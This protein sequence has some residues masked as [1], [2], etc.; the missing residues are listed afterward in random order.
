ML[1]RILFFLVVLNLSP[2][3]GTNIIFMMAD[4][5]GYGDPRCYNPESRI[6]TPHMDRLAA[7]GMRFTDA[8]TPSAVCTPTRYGV[9]TG[10]YAWRTHLKKGVLWGNSPALIPADRLTVAGMLKRFGYHTGVVGKWHLGLGDGLTKETD[11]SRPIQRGAKSV[12]FEYSYIIPASLDMDP[13][14]W[15]EN[16]LAVEAP[17][18]QDPGSKRVWDGGGGFWRA[19]LRAP[20]FTFDQVLPVIANKAADYIAERAKNRDQPFFLYVPLASPHTPWVPSADFRGKT[21]IGAYG[22]FVYETD[23]ALGK[24]LAALDE[25]ALTEDTLVIFT[26]D[27]GSHWPARMIG[28]SQHRANANWRGQKA[29]IHE[30]GHRVPF[31]VRWPAQVKAGTVSDQLICLTDLMATAAAIAGHSLL[32]SEGEDSFDLLPVLTGQTKKAVR[33][34]I[35]HHSL[36]GLFAIRI[37]KWKL[38]QGQGSGGFTKVPVGEE[39]P[40][41]QLYDLERDPSEATNL[42]TEKPKTVAKLQD[43]L[44]RFKDQG[45][46]RLPG[47]TA[48]LLDKLKLNQF[49][50][51]HQELFRTILRGHPRVALDAMKRLPGGLSED[52]ETH[53]MRAVAYSVLGEADQSVAS[54][55][56]AAANGV[57]VERIIGGT[58]TGLEAVQD[59][60]VI[61]KIREAMNDRVIHGPMLGRQTGN[62]V[63]VWVRTLGPSQ[64]T[65]EVSK[66][67]DFQATVLQGTAHSDKASDFTAEVLVDGLQPDT[68]YFYRLGINDGQPGEVHSF[69][70]LSLPHSPT[71][72]R[73]AFGGGAG[74]VPENERAWDTIRETNPQLLLLLGDNVYSDDPESPAMQHYCY[75]RRQAR[76][77][78]ARLVSQTPTY[79]IWDDHD[80]GLNDCVEGP[81]MDVPAWKRPVYGVY[82][83][84]WV[85]PGYGAGDAHPGCY[86]DFYQGDVH[87]IM[88]DGRYYR[89]LDETKGERSMLGPVQRRWLLDKLKDSQGVFKV[90]VS[91]VPWVFRAK[92]DSKDTWNGFKAERGIIFDFIKSNE[93]EGVLLMS[94][95]RHRSDLWKIDREEAYPFY[96]FNSS[97]LTNQHVHKTMDQALFSYNAKQSFGL[98]DIDTKAE[99]PTAT[100]SVVSIDG[101]V[102]HTFTVKRSELNH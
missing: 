74:Y 19:G 62:S 16:D 80:F 70:S 49:K 29:D 20:S 48:D 9:L 36:N 45:Y 26:S 31:L 82:R 75:Y 59:H 83:N 99:D 6:P 47:A 100:Y 61:A 14:L 73:L 89:N 8:H 44:K 93:I 92:G 101:E 17:T 66:D 96:E 39:E 43:T 28:E 11:Y 7:E 56:Q 52:G 64:V 57:P 40:A 53:Y 10:R 4:D 22:D 71:T 87:F 97:R 76:P 38:I 23:A 72:F 95:D 5:L 84:N 37:G 42:Y 81:E 24:V 3:W 85:N 54:A 27:N 102:V 63:S 79:T 15:L 68:D 88:L 91:P 86:Y 50:R 2:V 90:L 13:Y 25:H 35:V 67:E 21:R 51:I 98:V 78:F 65:V 18:V 1:A 33:K 69:K 41:G 32:E 58:L 94:A 60:P 46:S 12:G 77:E 55:L 34:S 30:G